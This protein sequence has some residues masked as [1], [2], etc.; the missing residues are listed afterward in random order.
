MLNIKHLATFTLSVFLIT[1]CGGSDDKAPVDDNTQ[2]PS[3]SLS[4]SDAP[5]DDLSQVV[6]CFNQI[7]LK[8]NGED[9]V[10]IVGN[11]NGMI[12]VNDLCLDNSGDIIPNTVGLDLLQYTGS[13]SIALVDGIS[14]EAGNYTQLR[15][16]MSDGSYGTDSETGEKISVSIPS[17][18]LKLDGFIANL[19]G[20]VDF[21]LEFDLN[22]GMTN[23]V[24]QAGYFLK[25]RGVRLV[26]NNEAGHIDGTVT[27]TLLIDNQCTPL[28]DSTTNVASVYIYEGADL[29]IDT[30]EDNGGDE[31]G[32]LPYASTAVTFDSEQT[33]YNFE[34]GF[35]KAGEYTIAVSCD[36][37]DD[38]EVDEEVSFLTSKNVAVISGNTPA[39]VDF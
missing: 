6:V 8:G 39:Q 38:P 14:I 20:T 19:G 23:P 29:V 33:S 34:I 27:E 10:F 31:T 2:L 18:E 7:E 37:E 1:A 16:I 28:S 5:V 30:L 22:K 11:E 32:N 35:I 24:G 15:L 17:N 26:N 21:T 9:A 25:P 13:D 3:F 12:G 4:V 36:T